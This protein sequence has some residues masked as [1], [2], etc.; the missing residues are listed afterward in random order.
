G[1]FWAG[2]TV[3]LVFILARLYTRHKVIRHFEADDYL[4]AAAWILYLV[5]TV[6]WTVL[7]DTLYYV[8]LDTDNTDT[9]DMTAYLKRYA[10]ALNAN[11]GTYYCTWTSLYI[12]KLSFMV[13]FNG[14]G[15]NLRAQRVLWWSVL[16]FIIVSYIVSVAMFDYSCMTADWAH[17]LEK[18]SSEETTDR[19]FFTSRV[20]ATLDVVTDALSEFPLTWFTFLGSGTLRS[21]VN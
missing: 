2:T 21:W 13:F 14:L 9:S 6:T 18:C 11:L 12:V 19:Q 3:S 7:D 1:V 10:Y 15:R 20:S 4:V 17:I 16:G 8:F 5:T